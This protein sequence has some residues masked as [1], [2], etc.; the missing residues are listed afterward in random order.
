MSPKKRSLPI[1][2]LLIFSI[3]AILIFS[4]NR[5]SLQ[6]LDLTPQNPNL[7]P[8]QSFSLTIKVLAYDRPPSLRRCLRSLASADYSGDS[9]DLHVFLDHFKNSSSNVDA[10]LEAS[11]RTLEFLDGFAWR[12]GRK[13]VHYRTGNAGLQAQ[14]LEAWWP[15]SDDEFAFV[16]ED[17]LEVSP[18]FYRYLKGLILKYYYDPANYSPSIYGAS[19]QRPRFVAG[20][21][22]NKL[23]VDD[24]VRLFL[25]QMVGTWGQ[26]LFPK[27]WKEF[28]LWYDEH[29]TKNIKP[30][31]EHMLVHLSDMQAFPTSL[32]LIVC[33]L[34]NVPYVG[35]NRMVQED[36]REDMDSLVHQIHPCSWLF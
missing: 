9:V 19:L 22:G 8:R 5:P 11:R 28:R 13:V 1:L 31:I 25:Y 27:P 15:G 32:S 35:N 14:W 23:Q 34:S 4:Y 36:G 24:D 17:D 7:T 2:L 18:V 3:T 16:V 10:N 12:F 6:T 21:H 29:K 26:L 33:Q 20:K 30:I